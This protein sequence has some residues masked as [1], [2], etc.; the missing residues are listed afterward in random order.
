MTVDVVVGLAVFTIGM[1]ASGV[2]IYRDQCR[3]RQE[4]NEKDMW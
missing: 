3:L 4:L 2:L 1:I